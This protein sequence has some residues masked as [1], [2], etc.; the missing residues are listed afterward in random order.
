M[1]TGGTRGE[2]ARERGKA[3]DCSVTGNDRGRGFRVDVMEHGT[4][5][6][7]SDDRTAYVSHTFGAFLGKPSMQGRDHHV[8][9]WRG[10]W[11][12]VGSV[13]LA[14]PCVGGMYCISNFGGSIVIS[15]PVILN[16]GSI[17]KIYGL[18]N[19]IEYDRR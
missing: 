7:L 3:F 9:P 8:N 12:V 6:R 4:K 14:T 16:G 18:F 15:T 11:S 2:G 17:F 5:G 10:R 13:P 19:E 1:G